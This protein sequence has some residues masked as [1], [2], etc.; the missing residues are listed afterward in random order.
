MRPLGRDKQMQQILDKAIAT[1]E[2]SDGEISALEDVMNRI[3]DVMDDEDWEAFEDDIL[4]RMNYQTPLEIAF[5]LSWDY[6]MP[7]DLDGFIY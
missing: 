7:L 1:E 6:D 5:S 3:A 2:F 4:E